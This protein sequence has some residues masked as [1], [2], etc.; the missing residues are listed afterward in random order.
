MKKTQRKPAASSGADH[1]LRTAAAPRRGQVARW[2]KPA[3][4]V[5]TLAVTAGLIT[6]GTFLAEPWAGERAS[7]QAHAEADDKT[8]PT[9]NKTPAPGPAPANMVWI[10]GGEFF[11][12]SEDFPDA[13]P[14]H[15]VY[16]DG[17]WMD[18]TEVTNAM[19]AEFVKET[20]YLTVAERRPDPGQ[21]P[22]LRPQVLGFQERYADYLLAGYPNAFPGMLMTAPAGGLPGAVP[23]GATVTLYPLVEPVSLVFHPPLIPK[24]LRDHTQWWALTRGASWRHPEGEGSTLFGREKHPTVHVCWQDAIAYCQWRSKKEKATYRLPTEAEWEFAA[25]GGLD[26][27]PYVWGDDL[28]PAGK[29][30]ANIWQGVFPMK[31]TKDDGYYRTAPAAT[32]PANGYGLHDMAGNVWEWCADCYQPDY[33]ENSPKRNPKGPS[34]G[35][36]PQDPGISKRVQRGGSFLCCD[37]YC[38]RY[39][40]GS[41]GK[42]EPTSAASHVGFRCLREPR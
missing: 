10:P 1:G 4:A 40:V 31:N 21:F 27:K 6:Y 9:L 24:G 11:M 13:H 19:F 8:P 35:F 39:M 3:A 41:R 22:H 23:W 18:K 16:V 15:K 36:D 37:N 26:R 42:G 28:L 2:W 33:Y 29:W 25:R 30:H 7:R 34:A 20:G 17:F 12:G 5:V 32:Y 14:I 38:V